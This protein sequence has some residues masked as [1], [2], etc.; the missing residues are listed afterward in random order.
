MVL[1][2]MLCVHVTPARAQ[3]PIDES[4]EEGIE[5]Q[6]PVHEAVC[7]RCD[8]EGF[9]HEYYVQAAMFSP[10]RSCVGKFKHV[11]NTS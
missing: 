11:V 1:L 10:D 4:V 6:E 8:C 3:W 9:R 5:T 2:C 7:V